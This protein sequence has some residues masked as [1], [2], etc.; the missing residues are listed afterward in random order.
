[1]KR[2][3]DS[4]LKGSAP[5][6]FCV[7]NNQDLNQVTWEQRVLTGDP[8]NPA[9]QQ[10]PDFPY[11]EYAG[12]LGFEGIRCER[13]D[14]VANAWKE[15]LATTDKPVILEVVTNREFPPLPPHIRLDMAKKMTKA[16][17]HGDEDSV[18]MMVKSAKG[19]LAEFKESLKP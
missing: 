9:T 10:I 1:V 4:H 3:W 7:F 5:L 16:V 14:G 11:A 8:R 12:L 2:Y 6:V 15:A 18:G 19:K 17:A 13:A